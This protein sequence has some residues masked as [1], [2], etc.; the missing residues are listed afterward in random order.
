LKGALSQD[1]VIYFLC[2]EIKSAPF[3]CIGADG[4]HVLKLNVYVDISLANRFR[5][6]NI[7]LN[8]LVVVFNCFSKAA[9]ELQK[10]VLKPH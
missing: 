2:S 4:F 10:D 3:F 1:F 5:I 9:W 8:P 6:F 7:S